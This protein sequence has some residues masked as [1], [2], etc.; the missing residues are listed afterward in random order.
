M[1]LLM[2][3]PSALVSE[4]FLTDS[5]QQFRGFV[6]LLHVAEKSQP[7]GEELGAETTWKVAV[8]AMSLAVNIQVQ[9][10]FET[11]QTYWT[12]KALP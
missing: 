4:G 6:L 2:S 5:A 3:V 1:N 7:A 12:F 8:D 11:F 9:A 10:A